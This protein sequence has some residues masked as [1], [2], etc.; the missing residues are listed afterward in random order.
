[1]KKV[2]SITLACAFILSACAEKEANPLETL[3]PKVLASFLHE[4]TGPAVGPCARVWAQPDQANSAALQECEDIA[5]TVAQLLEKEG[6]GKITADNIKLPA[7]W[8]EFNK[9]SDEKNKNRK[10]FNFEKW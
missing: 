1:M 8:I 6:Y 5:F 10:P 9:I 7:I 2:L 3:D 4:N